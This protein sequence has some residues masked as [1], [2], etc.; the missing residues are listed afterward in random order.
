VCGQCHVRQATLFQ[1]TTHKTVFDLMQ[2]GECVQC[3]SNHGIAQPTDE[4]LGVGEKSACTHCH[5]QGDSGYAA[6][7]QMREKIDQLSASLN[8]AIDILNRAERAGMEVSKPRFELNEAKDVLM[9]GRVLVHSFS[10]AELDKI[11]A[12]GLEVAMRS[13]DAGGAA[14]AELSFRRKGLAGSLVF[15]LLLA[16]LIYLKVREIER[17]NHEPQ[18]Q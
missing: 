1:P 2:A 15:I 13:Y 14:L 16:G 10:P 9:Q 3:H 17:R 6:A 5:G 11:V 4:M 18:N 12:P 8:H 7:R